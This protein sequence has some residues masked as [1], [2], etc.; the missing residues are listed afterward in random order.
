MEVFG[1]VLAAVGTLLFLAVSAYIVSRAISIAHFRTKLEYI[2]SIFRE[3]EHRN[4]S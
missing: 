1:Y 4:G 3:G 2:R